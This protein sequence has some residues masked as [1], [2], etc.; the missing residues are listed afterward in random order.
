MKAV[1]SCMVQNLQEK[2]VVDHDMALLKFLPK[3]S[4][5]YIYII[6]GFLKRRK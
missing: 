4:Q 2:A 3:E 6:R 5:G 1:M